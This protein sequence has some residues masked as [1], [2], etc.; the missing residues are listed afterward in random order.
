MVSGGGGWWRLSTPL[1][2]C[3]ARWFP[4]LL[5]WSQ[6]GLSV[7]EPRALMVAVVGGGC[8]GRSI[9]VWVLVVWVGVGVGFIYGKVNPYFRGVNEV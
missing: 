8:G 3:G 7:S 2:M 9:V 4:V 5:D 6:A 1:F